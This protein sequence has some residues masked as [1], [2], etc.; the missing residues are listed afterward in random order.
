M[1]SSKRGSYGQFSKL[2][3]Q[4]GDGQCPESE[5]K[6]TLPPGLDRVVSTL[7]KSIPI[8]HIFETNQMTG[9]VNEV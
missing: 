5:R 1:S 3:L 6:I 9:Y 2:L 8:L 4:I 7:I